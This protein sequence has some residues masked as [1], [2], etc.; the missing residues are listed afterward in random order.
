MN[1]LKIFFCKNRLS[2]SSYNRHE[3]PIVMQI[4]AYINLGSIG[5]E[6]WEL[7]GVQYLKKAAM[8]KT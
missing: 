4:Q 1:I 5:S 2:R 7:E 3:L 8:E 6:S